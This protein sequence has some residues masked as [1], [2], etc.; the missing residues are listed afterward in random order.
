NPLSS[1]KDRIGVSMIDALEAQG[2]IVPGKSV[3][4]EPTSGNTGVG[5]AFVAAARGY[6]LILTMPE[7]MSM[8]RRKLL[9]HLGAEL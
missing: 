8:E 3:L 9:A 6:R 1:V 5:L 7:T 2:R 4:V